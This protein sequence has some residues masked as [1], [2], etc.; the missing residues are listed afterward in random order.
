[1]PTPA[2]FGRTGALALAGA[3]ASARA[4]GESTESAAHAIRPTRLEA[5]QYALIDLATLG[6]RQAT[7]AQLCPAGR[8]LGWRTPRKTDGLS[9]SSRPAN[10]MPLRRSSGSWNPGS[11]CL[12]QS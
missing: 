8:C 2:L 12:P 9:L 4:Q 6:V 5:V 10:G 1:M 11:K 7:V 3:A